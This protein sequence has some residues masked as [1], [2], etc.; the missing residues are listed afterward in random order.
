MSRELEAVAVVGLALDFI[1]DCTLEDLHWKREL[2][3]L[4]E[5]VYNG[6]PACYIGLLPRT[7]KNRRRNLWVSNT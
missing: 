2:V 1:A 7:S 4:R 3:F 6:R 5:F